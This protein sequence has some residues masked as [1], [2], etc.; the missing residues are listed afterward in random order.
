VRLVN[1]YTA[2][3][4]Q[5]F[6][7]SH[8]DTYHHTLLVE[9][10]EDWQQFAFRGRHRKQ[11]EKYLRSRWSGSRDWIYFHE[12]PTEEPKAICKEIGM[13]LAKPTILLL[14]NVIWD[15]QLHYQQMPSQY[16]RLAHRNDPSF[17]SALS[18]TVIRR[19]SRNPRRSPRQ[20][21]VDEI[22]KHFPELPPNV[23]VGRTRSGH[24][25]WLSFAT[26]RSFTVLNWRADSMEFPVAPERHGSRKRA[27]HRPATASDYFAALILR[28][29]TRQGS[30]RP[31]AEVRLPFLL[32]THDSGQRH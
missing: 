26:L 13:D 5:R 27:H 31:R 17:A 11:A 10:S 14:T 19:P 20:P 29:A 3:R 32:Q 18:L 21:A 7:F 30:A 6:I 2:Y 15:A 25:P 28:W 16:D 8:G 24:M 4:K 23:Y 1:W 22:R 12:K 9:P